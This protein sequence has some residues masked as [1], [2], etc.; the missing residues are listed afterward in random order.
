MR[1]VL[2][3]FVYLV[4]L[5]MV[6][7]TLVTLSVAVTTTDFVTFPP[8]GFSMKWFLA[9]P[10]DAPLL[11]SLWRSFMLAAVVSLLTLAIAIPCALAIGGR[12]DGAPDRLLETL[13]AAP[14]MVPQIV[15]V[16]GLLL[17]YEMAGLAESFTGL[18]ISHLLFALPF[19]LR[20]LMVSVMSLDKRLAWSSAIL[21]AG[22]V[23]T[24][25][26]VIVPQIKT[27]IIATCIFAFILSFHNV[28]MALFLSG[29]GVRTF[30]VEMY[31]RMYIG[32]MAPVVPAIASLTAVVGV[33]LFVVLDRK[34]GLFKFLA[35]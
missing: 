18:V 24:F 16:L 5:M 28:T 26:M 15:L 29:V 3:G 11:A 19:A 6:L 7:P 20:T 8:A 25:I 13:V 21:G 27:G 1:G 4:V 33:A 31:Y 14:Q 22:P 34:I 2:R 35:A 10:G 9:I 32:G 30:P 12:G 23:R 17:F